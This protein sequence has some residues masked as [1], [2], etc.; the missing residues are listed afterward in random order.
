MEE[1]VLA[2][3]EMSTEVLADGEHLAPEL[4][5]FAFRMKGAER[6]CLV[7]DSSRAV[8]MPP[9]RYRFGPQTTASGSRA[10]ARSAISPARV[11]P[12]RSS[13][14]TRWCAT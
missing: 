9:G 2:H 12:A 3:D 7:T 4:L 6:L 10:T 13:A 14:W 8:D 1:F 5:D 11:W